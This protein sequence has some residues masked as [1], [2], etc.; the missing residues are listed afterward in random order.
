MSELVIVHGLG[1]HPRKHWFGWLAAELA[2]DGVHTRI[3]AMPE[4]DAPRASDWLATLA[5]LPIN[6]DTVLLGHSLGTITA[7]RF[8]AETGRRVRGLVLVAGFAERVP[9]IP[10]IDGFADGLT[11]LDRIQG[12][13]PRRIVLASDNDPIVP[14]ALSARLAAAIDAELLTVPG[15][16]HFM[17]SEGVTEL[18][19]A[20]AAV[21]SVLA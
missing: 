14:P 16:G 15:A 1:A 2:A 10:E 5:A 20:L 12:L 21:R 4:P 19:D 8:L 3:P 18:P 9:G 13:A 11:G 7:V 6:D 17:E